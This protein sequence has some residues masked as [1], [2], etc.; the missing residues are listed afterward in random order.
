MGQHTHIKNTGNYSGTGL[1]MQTT[2]TWFCGSRCMADKTVSA[3]RVKTLKRNQ[4]A[5]ENNNYRD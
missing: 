3:T 1:D 5:I 4:N 2:F